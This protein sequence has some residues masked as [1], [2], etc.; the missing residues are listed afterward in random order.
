MWSSEGER[1]IGFRY[2]RR[3]GSG[4]SWDGGGLRSSVNGGLIV[5]SS[6]LVRYSSREIAGAVKFVKERAAERIRA[7]D[8]LRFDFNVE[9]DADKI[10]RRVKG[11]SAL[12]SLISSSIGNRGSRG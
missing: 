11:G 6:D 3:A 5:D 7:M 12:S 10:L 2:L 1:L 9:V 8:A 4:G